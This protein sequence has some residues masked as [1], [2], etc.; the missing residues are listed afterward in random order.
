MLPRIPRI[1]SRDEQ[2][3]KFRGSSHSGILEYDVLIIGDS[4]TGAYI[5]LHAATRGL[6]VA[7]VERD[8][9]SSSTSQHPI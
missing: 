4:A 2:L 1:R 9:F 5:A 8:D 7:V 3:N 6:K